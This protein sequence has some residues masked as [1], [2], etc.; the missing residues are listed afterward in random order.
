MASKWL[1][2]VGIAMQAL[3]VSGGFVWRLYYDGIPEDSTTVES[4]REFPL[5]PSGPTFSE[6]LTQLEGVNNDGDYFGTWIR[7]YIQAP[8]TGEFTF[9]ISSDDGGEFWLSSNSS[10]GNKALIAEETACCAPLFAGA[11]LEERSGT[12]TLEKGS[13][14]YFE[15][16]HKENTGG[17]SII[18]G[19]RTPSGVEEV[20]CHSQTLACRQEDKAQV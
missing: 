13:S 18:A 6:S 15:I 10:A 16:F 14:Y 7:G 20:S 2:P 1:L 11:R 5:F 8:E 12:A 9:F 17:S 3:N 19:W 4:I